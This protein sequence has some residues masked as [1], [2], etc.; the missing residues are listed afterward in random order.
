[1]SRNLGVPL[2][3][4]AEINPPTP[5]LARLDPDDS[6]SHLPLSAVWPDGELDLSRQVRVG[7][8]NASHTVVREGDVIFPKVTPSFEHNR[9]AIARGLANGLAVASTEVHVVRPLRPELASIL[10]YRLR[11]AD[12]QAQGRAHMQGVAGLRRVPTRIVGD[13]PVL[14]EV[15]ERQE[16]IVDFLDRRLSQLGLLRRRLAGMVPL[17]RQARAAAIE[18]AFGVA[19][20]SGPRI[21]LWSAVDDARPIMY[22]IVLPGAHVAD[23]VPLVKAGDVHRDRVLLDALDRTAAAI[24]GKHARSRLRTGDVLLTIR[25]SVGDSA[26]VPEELNGANLTQ[27]TARIAPR[28][29]VSSAWLC[30]VLKAPSVQRWLAGLTA[31]A[32]IKGITIRDLKKIE[33]PMPPLVEQDRIVRA[34]EPR[35]RLLDRLCANAERM[36][37]LAIEYRDSLISEWT[38]TPGAARERALCAETDDGITSK[39]PALIS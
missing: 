32:S 36:N 7:D 4:L 29:G 33:V 23:G 3:Y 9:V 12:F 10:Q 31:G 19:A 16:W 15:I 5:E 22:G 27:D 6:I 20:A 1:M 34:I 13:L 18:E 38:L 39:A 26:I 24:D 14:S 37:E 2:R 21:P 17:A 30:L 35:L 11:A 25:G 8:A 28:H